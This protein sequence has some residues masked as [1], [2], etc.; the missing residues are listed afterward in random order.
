MI[1]IAIVSNIAILLLESIFNA[2]EEILGIIGPTAGVVSC[3]PSGG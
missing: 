1:S 3:R 2:H